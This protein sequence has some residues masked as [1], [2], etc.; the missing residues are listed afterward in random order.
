[1]KNTNQKAENA[2]KLSFMRLMKTDGDTGQTSV[3]ATLCITTFKD[4]TMNDG[5]TQD[6]EDAELKAFRQS[7]S[8]ETAQIPD[9]IE[10]DRSY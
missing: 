9:G 7:V 6:S 8:D 1:M 5:G 10:I 3:H 2:K 4:G